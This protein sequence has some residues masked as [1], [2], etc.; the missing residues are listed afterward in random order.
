MKEP[1]LVA[2]LTVHGVDSLDTKELARLEEWLRNEA[3]TL[4]LQQQ[5]LGKRY[6]SRLMKGGE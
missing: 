1:N 3:R 6:T 4:F 5:P 2:T